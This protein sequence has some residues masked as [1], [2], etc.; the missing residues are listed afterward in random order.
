MALPIWIYIYTTPYSL[1]YH[2][3]SLGVSQWAW[4]ASTSINQQW[5]FERRGKDKY[6]WVKFELDLKEQLAATWERRAAPFKELDNVSFD[7][8]MMFR[9]M[10][11]FDLNNYLM[12]CSKDANPDKVEQVEYSGIV[13]GHVYSILGVFQCDDANG[14]GAIRLVKLRNPWG[15]REWTGP[16]ADASA[17]WAAHPKIRKCIFNHATKSWKNMGALEHGPN[18]V[19]EISLLFFPAPPKYCIAII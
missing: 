16:W 7:D 1:N 11:K 18:R 15:A 17:E 8:S 12:T 14:C 3:L 2:S 9:L 5:Y 6:A 13:K 4:Q 19:V 10:D